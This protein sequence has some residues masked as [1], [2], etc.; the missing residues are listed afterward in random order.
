M[1]VEVNGWSRCRHV[2]WFVL[3]PGAHRQPLILPHLPNFWDKLLG[4]VDLSPLK[5]QVACVV[6][7]ED[8]MGDVL[9]GRCAE[10]RNAPIIIIPDEGNLLRI[11][12]VQLIGAGTDRF[13]VGVILYGAITGFR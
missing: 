12:I 9:G 11:V 1:D 4:Q 3:E 6:A 8:G 13:E 2:V 7:L 5:G 10:V